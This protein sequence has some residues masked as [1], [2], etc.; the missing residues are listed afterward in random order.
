VAVF[1]L[2]GTPALALSEL[3]IGPWHHARDLPSFDAAAGP[4]ESLWRIELARD[5][6]ASLA[7]LARGERS[8]VHTHALLDD[9][10]RRLERALATILP[11]LSGYQAPG[12]GGLERALVRAG[13]LAR[14][15]A[16]IETRVESTLVA[17]TLTTLSGN[18]EL[19][20]TPGL[21]PVGAELHARS[22]AVTVQTRHA[23]ARTLVLVLSWAG[24]IAALGMTGGVAALAM[25][26]RLI[27]DLLREIRDPASSAAR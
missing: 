18:L 16:R 20:I 1:E 23:W 11:D 13:E 4:P 7:A 27:R 17:R 14:G 19:W 24:R 10:P 25:A 26:W 3:A 5:P 2:G 21:S 22:V 15:R 6:V 12:A 9:A 8:I